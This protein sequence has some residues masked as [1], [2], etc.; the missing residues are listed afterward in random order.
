[1]SRPWLKRCAIGAMT[2]V[3]TVSSLPMAAFA[4][5]NGYNG[6]GNAFANVNG[7]QVTIGNDAITRTFSI[8]GEKLKT[9]EIDNKRA[10]TNLTPGADSEEFIIKRTKKENNV[11]PV[12]EPISTEGWTVSTDSEET[13]LETPNQ[14]YA[15]HLIDN[16]NQTIWHSDYKEGGVAVGNLP[17]HVD[18]EFGK[19][20]AFQSFAYD[21]RDNGGNPTAANGNISGYELLVN[22]DEAA[23][24]E[25]AADAWTSVSTGEFDYSGNKGEAIHVNLDAPQVAR[26]V[27]LVAKSSCNGKQLCGG[28]EFDLYAEK[29]VEPVKSDM[30]LKS[31]ELELE[32]DPVVSDTSATI[33]K[34]Q[35]A[36]KKLSFKF[37]PVEFNGAT[38][39]VTE[40]IVAYNGD[41]YMRKYL[42]ISV[43]D[44]DKL[45]AEIDYIDLE[46]LDVT[47]AEGQWT[48]PTNQGGIVGQPP[49]RAILGQPFYADGMFFGCEFPAANTQIVD[50]Q[51]K[52]I[53]RPRY[54]T[55]KTMDRL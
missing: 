53:G 5:P 30:F 51:G 29:W 1:M 50:E 25:D 4:D 28:E 38:Y 34:Q 10:N 9:I 55:G 35:K 17:H 36:G 52:Q 6:G 3:M 23:P 27:R 37:K 22:N 26:R 8:A 45:R 24:A 12:Q 13:E 31:S 14:G 39:T 47:G 33:N 42:E 48:I 11:E 44:A 15:R 41:H 16:N 7:E 20:I 40:N 43:P 2:V 49:A 32:G 19:E 46:S 54:Y 18:F 21:P